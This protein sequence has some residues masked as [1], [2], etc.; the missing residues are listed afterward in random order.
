M[1]VLPEAMWQRVLRQDHD[2]SL[3]VTPCFYTEHVKWKRE[4]LQ[5]MLAA[6]GHNLGK[7]PVYGPTSELGSVPA[8]ALPSLSLAIIGV[9]CDD[10][11]NQTR[12]PK[13]IVDASGHSGSSFLEFHNFIKGL[14]WSKKP[15]AIMRE[16]V[17]NLDAHRQSLDEKGTSVIDDLMR[18][19]GYVS[20]FQATLLLWD[21]GLFGCETHSGLMEAV[22]IDSTQLL[23]VVNTYNFVLPQSRNR[24][25]GISLKV[26]PGLVPLAAAYRN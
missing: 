19:Q 12:T 20:C 11:S 13:S 21:S 25:Y 17:K 16:C 4:V 14:E 7:V 3:E 6:Q 2:I 24:I 18:K 22:Q 26:Q 5:K 15:V 9:E 10:V 8:A 1:P 23:K